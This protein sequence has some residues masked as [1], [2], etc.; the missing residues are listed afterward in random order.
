VKQTE[1]P[2]MLVRAACLASLLLL[3]ASPALAASPELLPISGWLADSDGEPLDGDVELIIRLYS[4]E[5][6]TTADFTDTVTVEVD[7]GFFTAYA[8]TNASLDLALFADYDEI[9]LGLAVDPDPEMSPRIQLA[10]APWAAWAEFAGVADDAL[11][12]DGVPASEYLQAGQDT[13]ASLPCGDGQVPVWD[14]GAA[15]WGCDDPSATESDPV[16]SASDVSAIGA[17]E[18]GQWST[19]YGWGDHAAAGY[20]TSEADPD[21]AASPAGGITAGQISGWDSAAAW[22]DHAAAG[23]VSTEAD[24]VF[25][26]SAAVGISSTHVGNWDD[27]FGWGDHGGEGYLTSESDPDFAASTASGIGATDVINW[28]AAYGWG[29]HASAGYVGTEA[30]PVFAA[31]AAYGISTGNIAGWNTAWGWGNHALVGYLTGE[32]D[33]VFT[34]SAASSVGLTDIANW[35]DAYGWGDHAAAGYA[36]TSAAN[37]NYVN[38]TGDTMSGDLELSSANANI[39]IWNSGSETLAGLTL[40]DGDAPSTQYSNIFYDAGGEELQIAVDGN[41]ILTIEDDQEVGIGTTNPTA[42]LDVHGTV[43]TNGNAWALAASF[44][45]SQDDVSTAGLNSSGL[46]TGTDNCTNQTLPFNVTIG[47]ELFG[48]VCICTDGYLEFRS[49]SDTS[50]DAD[51]SNEAVP[52]NDFSE[53]ALFAYWDDL[54][55]NSS[56]GSGIIYG[57]TGSSPNRTWLA[58]WDCEKWATNFDVQFQVQVHEGSGLMNVRY[59]NMHPSATGGSATIGFQTQGASSARGY[60]ISYNTQILDDN[61][62][63]SDAGHESWSIAPIR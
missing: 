7:E 31:S 39:A 42:T 1:E 2:T 27:A 58:Q 37:N 11:M 51:F 25:G 13:L 47:G 55:C 41:T 33:P 15:A 57:H 8:G 32:I 26:A 4:S 34:A 9:W 12:L 60:P 53:P 62:D 3:V 24:P 19:A 63:D 45:Y 28:N 29:N 38:V 49:A 43:E 16:F 52:T 17:A 50:C 40:G 18:I 22:G 5:G 35:E 48:R 61:A 36:T 20:V 54:D 46:L 14:D 59:F 6:A 30:D 21:F 10:T 44:A 56:N 23:Y